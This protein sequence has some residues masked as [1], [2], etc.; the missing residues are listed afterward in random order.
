MRDKQ[1]CVV[2]IQNLVD[3]QV[4]IQN[5]ASEP[6][7]IIQSQNDT[8][9]TITFRTP[10]TPVRIKKILNIGNNRS[11][12]LFELNANTCAVHIDDERVHDHLFEELDIE[13]EILI[14]EENREFLEEYNE[15]NLPHKYEEDKLLDLNE[16]ERETLID[17]LLNNVKI[18]TDNQKKTLSFLASL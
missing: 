8:V 5:I 7:R 18:L 9:A 1:Y 12:F 11:F 13:T 17:K 2:V 14:E 16:E 10:L 6:I 4:D 3:A 15:S